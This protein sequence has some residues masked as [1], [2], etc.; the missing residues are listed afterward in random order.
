MAQAQKGD[1]VKIHFT[2]RLEDGSIFDTTA[3][4]EGECCSGDCSG[5]HEAF[6]MVLGNEE[7]FIPVEEALVGMAPGEK[8]TIKVSPEDAFGDYDDECVFTIER[9]QLPD[10]MVPEAGM[11]VE[12]T[13]EDDQSVVVSVVEVTDT[14][15]TFDANHP[16]AGEELTLDIELVEII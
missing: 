1:R 6:E 9:S 2:G 15:I 4:A 3:A 11:E 8:K 5:E 7:F 12:L 16:L 14:T 10:D 13:D